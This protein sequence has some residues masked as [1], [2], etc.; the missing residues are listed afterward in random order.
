[1]HVL[2]EE[3]NFRRKAIAE[4]MNAM[5]ETTSTSQKCNAVLVVSTS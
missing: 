5:S 1:M 2:D 4:I 3:G